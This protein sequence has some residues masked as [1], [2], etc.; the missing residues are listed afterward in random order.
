MAFRGTPS[1]VAAPGRTEAGLSCKREVKRVAQT[2][3]ISNVVLTTDA[4]KITKETE[5]QGRGGK[6]GFQSNSREAAQ[7]VCLK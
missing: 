2:L 4:T 7:D 1:D 5:I 6:V 3:Q